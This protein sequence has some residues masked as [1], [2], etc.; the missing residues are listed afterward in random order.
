MLFDRARILAVMG[1]NKIFCAEVSLYCAELLN[2]WSAS[3]PAYSVD[4][5]ARSAE[6]ACLAAQLYESIEVQGDAEEQNAHMVSRV[7]VC[8][9]REMKS[10]ARVS[11]CQGTIPYVKVPYILC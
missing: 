8:M 5:M 11:L 6:Y 2:K 9:S 4:T 1:S 10:C 3:D 7:Y